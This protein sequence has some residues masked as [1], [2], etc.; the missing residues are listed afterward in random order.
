MAEILHR[1]IGSL[2]HCLQGFIHPR[3]C[4]ISAINSRSDRFILK[5]VHSPKLTDIPPFRRPRAPKGNS[6]EPTPVFQGRDVSF[7]EARDYENIPAV[8]VVLSHLTKTTVFLLANC[9]YYTILQNHMQLW[10]WVERT[11]WKWA[12][13]EICIYCNFHI[14]KEPFCYPR[15]FEGFQWGCAH[16]S[17]AL[18]KKKLN[19]S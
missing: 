16:W 15:I 9:C 1:L 14:L 8:L 17:D 11:G 4:R 12:S 2:S 5:T 19:P 10:L 13:I 6:S 18:N 3:W 7:R